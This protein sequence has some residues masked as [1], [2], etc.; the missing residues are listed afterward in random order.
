[1]HCSSRIRLDAH[2]DHVA[3]TRIAEDARFD[4]K[5]T[6]IGIPG[7][8]WIPSASSTISARTCA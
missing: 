8:P 6:K 4:A 5:L 1:M 3:V 2:P 7:E